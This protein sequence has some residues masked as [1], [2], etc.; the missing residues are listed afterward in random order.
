MA[1][2]WNPEGKEKFKK[3]KKY[4]IKWCDL[5]YGIRIKVINNTVE[6]VELFD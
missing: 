4:A 5:C 2:E 6:W 1:S 3:S